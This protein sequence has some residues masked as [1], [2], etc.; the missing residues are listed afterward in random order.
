LQQIVWN[1]VSN[2]IRFTPPG[3][4]VQ[5]GLRRLESQVEI[6]VRDTGIGI[7]SGF[8][9]Y[10]FDRFR[11][12]DSSSKRKQGGLGL[13]LAIVR[14]LVELHSGS[15]EAHSPGEGRGTAFTVKLP[16]T[17][18]RGAIAHDRMPPPPDYE[19]VNKARATRLRGLRVLAVDDEPSA[20]ELVISILNQGQAD[21][22]TA[23]SAAEALAILSDWSPE[24]LISDIEMPGT[25]GYSLI[26][27]IRA[28]PDERAQVPAIALTAYARNEDR[29]RA[30][31]A[32]FQMYIPKP[33]EPADLLS[34]VASVS[35]K[36]CQMRKASRNS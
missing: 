26:R 4:Q 22:K 10:V 3:G 1:L 32:G 13:G 34:A 9:P 35:E 6:T 25:D 2:A 18:A 8:L 11:Q 27:R 14:H 20:R 33:V 7:S 16:R 21:V 17:A 31:A 28:L 12:A 19:R 24:V 5:V 30:L 15:V 29:A 23:A 36:S